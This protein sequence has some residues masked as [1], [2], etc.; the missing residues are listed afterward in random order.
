MLPVI[1][2]FE[3]IYLKKPDV[4]VYK[5]TNPSTPDTGRDWADK[6]AHER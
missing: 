1:G 2:F 5:V 4:L 6:F 3:R